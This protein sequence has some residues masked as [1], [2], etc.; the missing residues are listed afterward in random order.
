MVSIRLDTNCTNEKSKY[1]RIRI[2]PM[3]T[4]S[5]FTKTHEKIDQNKTFSKKI[6]KF[7]SKF[8]YESSK[9]RGD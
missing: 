1:T 9:L 4:H 3:S 7:W 6:K 8:Q 5:E 2:V